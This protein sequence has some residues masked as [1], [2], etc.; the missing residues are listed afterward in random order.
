LVTF[1]REKDF[2]DRGSGLMTTEK[3]DFIVIYG[4]N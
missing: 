1:N 2:R 3:E 4:D